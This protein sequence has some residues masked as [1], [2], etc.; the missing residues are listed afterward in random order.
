[1]VDLQQNV[2]PAGVCF[3]IKKVKRADMN[4]YKINGGATII[5]GYRYAQCLTKIILIKVR[6]WRFWRLCAALNIQTHSNWFKNCK[7]I[8]IIRLNW[9]ET[10]PLFPV[11][12]N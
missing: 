7:N 4:E 6:L 9:I 1:M 10:V 5:G 3:G 8:L 11:W 2:R 12:R